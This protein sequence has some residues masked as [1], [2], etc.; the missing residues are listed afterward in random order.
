MVTYI[1]LIAVAN[2]GLGF[3]LAVCLS[4][5]QPAARALTAPVCTQPA[6]GSSAAVASDPFVVAPENEAGATETEDAAAQC[7]A[8]MESAVSVADEEPSAAL[9]EP[10]IAGEPAH[11][12]PSPA[13]SSLV[14]LPTAGRHYEDV[15]T[16]VADDLRSPAT[17][18][19]P[20]WLE[21]AGESQ[22]TDPVTGLADRVGLESELA[23]WWNQDVQRVRRLSAAMI[24]LDHFARLNENGGPNLGN[25][26]LRAVATLLSAESHGNPFLSRYGGQQFVILFPDSGV[27]EAMSIVEKVRQT[28]EATEF[29][30]ATRTARITLSCGLT[31]STAEDTSQSLLDRLESTVGEAKRYGRNR[32]FVHE[33]KYPT[34][35]VPPNLALQP[36][37]FDL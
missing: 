29:Q 31:E 12:E 22:R 5:Q 13:E 33:G 17:S 36:Q 21:D 15:L 19:S 23:R 1:L 35:V 8:P 37:T 10:D 25:Q 3:A 7:D 20:Q 6:A 11:R 2:L 32:T 30:A 9:S 16:E 28:I 27:R 26:M 14:A 24:D 34:P 18:P 4:R